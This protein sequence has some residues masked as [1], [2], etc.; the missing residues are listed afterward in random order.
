MFVCEFLT[1]QMLKL[2]RNFNCNAGNVTSPDRDTYDEI[3]GANVT[4]TVTVSDCD[5]LPA[6]AKA[7]IQAAG[8]R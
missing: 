3:D 4:G 1:R 5:A 8:P 7:I 2:G 6:A